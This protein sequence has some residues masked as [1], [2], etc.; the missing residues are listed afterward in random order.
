MNLK[1]IEKMDNVMRF[2][3]QD[4]F[5]LSLGLLFITTTMI[6]VPLCDQSSLRKMFVN[7][8]SHTA[9]STFH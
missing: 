9:G 7:I 5:K 8:K 6:F 1:R 2:T 4:T 3:C